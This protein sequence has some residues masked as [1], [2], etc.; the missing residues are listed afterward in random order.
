MALTKN[1]RFIDTVKWAASIAQIAGYTATGF[2]WT[3]WNIGFFIFGLL[4]WLAVG[5]MWR[6]KA[7]VLVHLVAFGAMVGGM[8][9]R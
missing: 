4:G 6:D 5:L 2:G 8:L 9:T 7:L 1:Q 3:P